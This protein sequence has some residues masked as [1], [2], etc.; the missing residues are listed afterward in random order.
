MEGHVIGKQQC[1]FSENRNASFQKA[2]MRDFR[3]QE[4]RFSEN[5]NVSFIPFSPFSMIVFKGDPKA[6]VDFG[7]HGYMMIRIQDLRTG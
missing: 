7:L 1:E 4:C 2:G 6:E 3:K 5:R